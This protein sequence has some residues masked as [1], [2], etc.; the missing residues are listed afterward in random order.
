MV[1]FVPVVFGLFIALNIVTWSRYRIN[2]VFIFGLS[3]SSLQG[4]T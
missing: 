1:L 4:F 2:Y 3:I